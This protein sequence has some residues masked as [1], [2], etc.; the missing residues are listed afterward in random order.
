[1]KNQRP[2]GSIHLDESRFCDSATGD[3]GAPGDYYQ[4]DTIR[5]KFVSRANR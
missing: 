1:M 4:K 2:A 3:N 5:R